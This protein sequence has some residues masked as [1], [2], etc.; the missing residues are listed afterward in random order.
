MPLLRENKYDKQYKMYRLYSTCYIYTVTGRVNMHTPNLQYIPRDFSIDNMISEENTNEEEYFQVNDEMSQYGI[1]LRNVFIASE[2]LFIFF[3][4][5]N[6][7]I[8]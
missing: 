7:K 6:Q 5:Q 2:G 3:F 4:I 8:T 1:S